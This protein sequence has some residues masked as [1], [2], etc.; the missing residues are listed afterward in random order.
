MTF[1]TFLTFEETILSSIQYSFKMHYIKGIK[2]FVDA[3]SRYPVGQPDADDLDWSIS[4]ELSSLHLV[5][6][7]T[8]NLLLISISYRMIPSTIWLI[9]SEFLI[10]SRLIV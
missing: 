8:T 7:L 2:N 5:N 6:N 4:L 1:Q 3:F 10:F 9:F